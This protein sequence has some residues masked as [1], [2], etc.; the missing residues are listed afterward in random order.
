MSGRE[1]ATNVESERGIKVDG[2]GI[3]RF[4]LKA[5]WDEDNSQTDP[6]STVGRQ[7]S[8]TKDVS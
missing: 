4:D 8:A 1:Y 6:E 2:R 5:A 3:C 7:R